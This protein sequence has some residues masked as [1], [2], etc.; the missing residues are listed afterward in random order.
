[1]KTYQNIFLSF[2]IK[3]TKRNFLILLLFYILE[4]SLGMY[5]FLFINN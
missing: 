1:M 2:L 5:I 3:L 4:L